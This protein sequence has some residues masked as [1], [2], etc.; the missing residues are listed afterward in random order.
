MIGAGSQLAE[1]LAFL[2]LGPPSCQACKDLSDQ[3]DASGLDWC[4]ASVDLLVDRIMENSASISLTP[5]KRLAV[6]GL[7]LSAIAAARRRS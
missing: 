5:L 2:R 1:I 6:R 3:M 7:V 4:S